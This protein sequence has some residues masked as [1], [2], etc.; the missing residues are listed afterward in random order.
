MKRP[1]LGV[2]ALAIAGGLVCVLGASPAKADV[3]NETINQ[4]NSA[5][6]GFTPGYVS[7]QINRTDTTHATATF[8]SLSS[9]TTLYR[10]GDGS[11][12]DLNVAGSFSAALGSESGTATGFTPTFSAFSSG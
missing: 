10:M 3:I 1:P 11:S 6:S 2:A 4:P 8:T 5:L 12:A 9:G 7:L